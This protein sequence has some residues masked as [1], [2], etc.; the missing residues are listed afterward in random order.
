MA[1][2]YSSLLEMYVQVDA[3]KVSGWVRHGESILAASQEAGFSMYEA[4]ALLREYERFHVA[5]EVR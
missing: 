3:K 2:I 4:E 5:I 1:E